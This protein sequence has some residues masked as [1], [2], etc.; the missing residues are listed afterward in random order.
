MHLVTTFAKALY[1]RN[2]TGWINPNKVK[3]LVPRCMP[4]ALA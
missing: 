1:D 3:A 2:G 4:P